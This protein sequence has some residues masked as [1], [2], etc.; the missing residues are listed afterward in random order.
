MTEL[1][2]YD[3]QQKFV[4]PKGESIHARIHFPDG[5]IARVGTWFLPG[6]LIDNY[7]AQAN[8]GWHTF[9]ALKQGATKVEW[10]MGD[11]PTSSEQFDH[12]Q[13]RHATKQKPKA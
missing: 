4:R 13:M 8:I 6:G 7:D 12:A 11:V 9:L 3:I 1:D 2:Q 10:I 5:R